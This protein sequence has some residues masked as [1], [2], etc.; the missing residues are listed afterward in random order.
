MN[1]KPLGYKA[2]GSIPHLPGSRRGPGDHGI[3]EQQAKILT[4]KT[5][6]KHDVVIVT[7]KVDGSNVCVARHEGKL[8]ALG[9]AGYLASSSP[10][11]QHQLFAAWVR[12]HETA[13]DFLD[14]GMRL[15][16]EWMIQAHGTRYD[17]SP[18]LP[19]MV[20]DIFYGQER[21][22]MHE[23][24][25]F[26]T[27]PLCVVNLLHRG[28]ALS[29]EDAL[30]LLDAYEKQHINYP[31]TDDRAEGCVWRVERDGKFDFMAKYVR[32]EKEDGKYLENV[33]GKGPVWNVDIAKFKESLRV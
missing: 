18:L 28:E 32:P 12:K 33:T 21:L 25:A 22:P 26:D 30:C 23:W 16:G 14:D 2:Y 6:D 31:G 15:S 11:E 5:R 24:P 20:F 7:E 19:L 27:P 9:R 13:F 1:I 17:I 4:E 8:L 10:F 29:V 3:S